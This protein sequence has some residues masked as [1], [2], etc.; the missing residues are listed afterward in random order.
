MI[1]ITFIT[2]QGKTAEIAE[3]TNL[4]RASLRAQ[5]GI[6]F[7]CGGGLCG[8]CKCTIESGRENVDEIKPKERKHLTE[9][10]LAHG[11]RLACQTFVHGDIS[12][13]W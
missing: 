9:E 3:K 10:Q 5:G 7:K 12:V 8:T 13:S 4:L 2:N 11:R 1:R 6:P